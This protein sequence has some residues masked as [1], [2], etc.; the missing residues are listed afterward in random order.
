MVVLVRER[1]EAAAASGRRLCCVRVRWVRGGAAVRGGERES[2]TTAARETLE[3]GAQVVQA[4][5]QSGQLLA[6]LARALL[7]RNNQCIG[8]WMPNDVS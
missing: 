7:E 4:R 2:A 5:T 6:V 3:L 8:I 1:P